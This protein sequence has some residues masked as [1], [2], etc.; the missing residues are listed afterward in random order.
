MD[1]ELAQ[2]F[3]AALDNDYVMAA[4]FFLD[5]VFLAFGGSALKKAVSRDES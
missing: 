2:A 1:P 5:L 3:Q 4:G